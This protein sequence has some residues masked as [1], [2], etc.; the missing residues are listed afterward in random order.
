MDCVSGRCRHWARL[1]LP[2]AW[3]QPVSLRVVGRTTSPHPP[4]IPSERSDEGSRVQT[5]RRPCARS[6]VAALARDDVLCP[7][8]PT[9]LQLPLTGPLNEADPTRPRGWVT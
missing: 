8:S 4:V 9:E 3:G 6:F 2:L 7:S 5:T 1:W